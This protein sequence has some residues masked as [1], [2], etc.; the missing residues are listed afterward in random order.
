MSE[1]NRV[2]L[3]TGGCGF[4]GKHLLTL[5]LEKEDNLV[6]IRVFDKHRF[7]FRGTQHRADQ[8]FFSRVVT[9]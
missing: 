5:L 3:I 1:N 2:Y 8:M 4:L 7:E 6:E 9:Q